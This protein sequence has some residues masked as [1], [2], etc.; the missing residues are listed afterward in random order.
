[1]H[2]NT[3]ITVVDSHTEGMPT[4]IVTSG[5]G[6]VPGSTM[7]EKQRYIQENVD[8]LRSLLM[9]EPRGHQVMNGAILLP[10]C[11]P[12]ADLGVVFIDVDGYLGM[13][14]HGTI[15]TC[16][17]AIE[18]GLIAPVEPVTRIVL[19]TPAGRVTA[20]A[21]V[22]NGR[23][24]KVKLQ[25]VPSFLYQR[26]IHVHVPDLGMF[27]IDIAY[28]G[29]FYAILPAAAVDLTLDKHNSQALLTIGM[30][31]MRAMRA[32]ISLRHPL[33]SEDTILKHVM[34]TGPA[35]GAGATAKN[36]V[37]IAPGVF[38][39]SP[40]GTGTS[41]RMAQLFAHQQLALQQD[42]VHESITGSLF[43]GRL[44]EQVRLTPEVVAVIPTIEGRAWIS[45][46]Q[47]LVLDPEDPFPAG[48]VLE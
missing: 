7:S 25:N 8:S 48:F 4:R 45:G 20:E 27:S 21:T 5:F 22:Q 16:T 2:F 13:C 44:I 18:T 46:F 39:R 15:G 42:F 34:F 28:G 47:N 29:N 38:D 9:C 14:G 32:Q 17:V 12:G 10:P 24:K 11:A 6:T 43:T 19:D 40:C 37:V 30:Q 41:A 1:M 3:M 26:D 36:A 33:S 35:D 23:V 31:I